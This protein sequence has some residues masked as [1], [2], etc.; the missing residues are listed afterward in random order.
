MSFKRILF[1]AA[2]AGLAGLGCTVD[3]SSDD[4]TGYYFTGTVYDGLE[5][6]PLTAGYT[7]RLIQG[8]NTEEVEVKK[9]DNGKF[10]IGPVK[11]GSDYII[12]IE[13]EDY[14]EFYAAEPLKTALPSNVEQQTTQ[15]YEAYLFPKSLQ[16]PP[17]T[18]AVFGEDSTSPRPTGSVRFAPTGTG[19]SALD[20][21]ADFAPAIA[22]HLWTNDADLKTGTKILTLQDGEIKIGEG[23]LVYGVTYEATVYDVSGNA[24]QAFNFTAG[25]SGHQTITLSDLSDDTLRVTSSSLDT[26]N[27]SS[28]GSV[29]FTFNFPIEFSPSTPQ[30]YVAELIDDG[31]QISATDDDGDGVSNQLIATDSPTQREHNTSVAIDGNKLTLKWPGHDQAAAF[32]PNAFDPD[33]LWDVT[34]PTAG[35]L[36]RRTGATDT[37]ARPLSSMLA[38]RGGLGTSVTVNLKTPQP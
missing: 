18:I 12:E 1:G 29:T 2:F 31:I 33:D 17:V 34:Y 14:R 6:K 26:G 21:G 8:P 3:H 15:Y 35:I 27:I 16:S 19:G 11:P 36:V 38:E 13:N 25:L 22:G 24:Y 9:S 32:E 5:G 10:A 20:L 4:A 7:I 37:D 23:E 28:D 30:D